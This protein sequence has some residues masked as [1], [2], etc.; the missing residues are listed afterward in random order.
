MEKSMVQINIKGGL[1]LPPAL[2]I[3]SMSSMT[4]ETISELLDKYAKP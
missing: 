2:G 3:H 1:S 4:Y